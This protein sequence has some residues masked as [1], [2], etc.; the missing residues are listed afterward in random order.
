MNKKFN[1]TH[2]MERYKINVKIVNECKN[3]FRNS[4]DSIDAYY[5]YIEDHEVQHLVNEFGKRC[6]L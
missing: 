2:V 5:K 3:K 1:A 4:F 6:G